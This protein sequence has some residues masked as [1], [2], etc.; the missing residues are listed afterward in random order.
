MPDEPTLFD[1]RPSWRLDE[2]LV[3]RRVSYDTANRWLEAYH[4][5]GGCPSQAGAVWCISLFAGVDAIATV[6]IGHPAN[7]HG[8]AAR[9]GLTAWPGN[10]EITRVAVHPDAPKNTASR[11]IAAALRW[12]HTATR[13]EWVF[14]YADTGQN[15][16]GG[17]YQALNAVYCGVSE[18][19]SGYLLD[20]KPLHPRTLVSAYG[21]QSAET[22]ARLQAGG[23]NIVK[24]DDLNSAKHT[25]VVPCGG[26][27]SRRAIRRALFDVA[28]P[29]PKRLDVVEADVA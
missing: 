19:R 14:S 9:F 8:V 26:P 25:F 15:H 2:D 4:Y 7:A 11:A 27:A 23:M 21:S 1:L 17:I 5:L 12:Y 3:A 24:V 20:G 29:Y 16:H 22:V 6:V 13:H 28:K 10:F 18:A